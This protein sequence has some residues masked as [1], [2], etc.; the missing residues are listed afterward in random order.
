RRLLVAAGP[1]A[2][3]VLDALMCGQHPGTWRL[4]ECQAGLDWLADGW[5]MEHG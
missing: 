3:P 2:G 4:P 1:I 5:G